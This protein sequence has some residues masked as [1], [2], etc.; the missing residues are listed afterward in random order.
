MPTDVAHMLLELLSGVVVG[1]TLGLIGGGGSIL[2]VPLMVYVV[3]VPNAHVAIGTSAVSV[4]ANALAGLGYH[5]RARTVKW[6]CAGIFASCG[7][8]GALVGA[9][10]GKAV[11]GQ[12]L[13]LCFAILMIGVGFLMLR[14]RHDQGCADAQCT[15]DNAPRVMAFGGLTGILSGFFG[16]GGGFL[17]VPGLIASTHMPILN[18]V[19]TSLVAVAAF[20]LSTAISYM[21][22]GYVDWGM[23][24]LFIVGG[25]LGSY[26]GMRVSRRMAGASGALTIFFAGV[27][28]C[29]ATYMIWRSLR[30]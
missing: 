21:L 10:A 18:A 15:R 23:A 8:L 12:K 13:L 9:S 2:A 26:A 4:A 6:R 17:I 27:I 3:G 19:G 11:D 24:A 16:I 7:I 14:G 30:G 1:F 5:A 28:F 22:S 29:V 20:G 25:T